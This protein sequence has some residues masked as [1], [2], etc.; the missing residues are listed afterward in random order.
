MLALSDMILYFF[1]HCMGQTKHI[2]GPA[3]AYGPP[4]CTVLVY[5]TLFHTFLFYVPRRALRS[6]EVGS[7]LSLYY[8]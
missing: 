4:V 3:G 7:C 6:R 5:A 8:K 2:C 1:K